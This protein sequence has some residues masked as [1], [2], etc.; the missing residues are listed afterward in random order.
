MTAKINLA[1]Y[2]SGIMGSKADIV[3]HYSEMIRNAE[4]NIG[5]TTLHGSI[6]TEKF[7]GS[8][9]KRRNELAGRL[10]KGV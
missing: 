6:I 9:K 8:L 2:K 10:F 7:I 5:K 4:M 1:T 3:R